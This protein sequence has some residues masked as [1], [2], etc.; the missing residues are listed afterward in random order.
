MLS[1][2]KYFREE[3][4]SQIRDK[5]CIAGECKALS[6][7]VIDKEKCRGCGLCKNNCPV[8]AITGQV[9]NPHVIDS[10]KC[11][12]CGTCIEKCPFKAISKI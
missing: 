9:K 5:K 8:N 12:K 6:N 11:I 4:W 10:E 2:L 7:I 3:Y 1:T